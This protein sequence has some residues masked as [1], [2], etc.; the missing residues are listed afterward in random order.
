LAV[1]ALSAAL[2]AGQLRNGESP[3]SSDY[4]M[5]LSMEKHSAAGPAWLRVIFE[6]RATVNN[7][8]VWPCLLF[9]PIIF[10]CESA[11]AQTQSITGNIDTVAEEGNQFYLYGW[12]CAQTYNDPIAVHVYVGGPY[13]SGVFLTSAVASQPSEPAVAA[14]CNASG[15]NYRFKI[16]ITPEMRQSYEGHEIYVHG[17]SPFQLDNLL[18][19]N[20]GNLT[21]P[22]SPSI[23]GGMEGIAF[24][25]G[26]FYIYGWA[27]AQTYNDSVS[28]HVYV[29]APGWSGGK[30]MTSVV[31]S[32]YSEPA[33]AAACHASGSYYRFGIPITYAMQQ[34]YEGQ[35]IYVH[36][37]SPFGLGNS[38]IGNS[39]NLAI[40][41]T[42]SIVGNIEAVA[43]E[44]PS[45]LYLFG[46]A[47]AQ[48][49]NDPVA[50]HVYV[51]GSVWSG[52]TFMTSAVASQPSEP[53]VAAACNASGS[54]YRF[55]IPIT[56]EMQQ[57]Y[58]GQAIYVYGISPVGP[59]HLL[60]NGSGYLSV[61]NYVPSI[62]K[63]IPANAARGSSIA[64]TMTGRNL[65]GAALSTPWSGLTIGS[66]SSTDTTITATFTLSSSADVGMAPVLMTNANGFSASAHISI[67]PYG[68]EK[69][70]IY[71]DG[72]LV[73]TEISAVGQ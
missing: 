21:V 4:K 28:L 40:P 14:A 9:V 42:Q 36:G 7:W 1:T 68:T 3:S 12:A 63:T 29:G 25:G 64:I 44:G 48:A 5:R 47:C 11:F 50:V 18:I 66:V 34:Q 49:Y 13:G 35:A 39:G 38:L 52:G 19:G 43:L 30:F 59:H 31:A 56:P 62:T 15:S 65:N 33:V 32:Q 73:A 69:E 37:I 16:P 17:I 27:C 53:A 70:Y 26:L 8:K 60:I 54:N 67:R 24:S 72:K 20:S 57:Q 41:L 61:L 10:L 6:R 45:Q 58:E 46:W 23:T 22:M 71:L 51:G 55:K 2:S